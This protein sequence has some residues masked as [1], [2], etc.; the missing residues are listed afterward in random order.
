MILIFVPMHNQIEN[1]DTQGEIRRI[2]IIEDIAAKLKR[3]GASL[4]FTTTKLDNIEADHR[5]VEACAN[6]L[7]TLWLQGHVQDVSQAPITWR[8]F[9]EALRDCR[10]GQLA[11]TLTDL[12]TSHDD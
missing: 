2:F 4:K 7:L 5:E 6:R 1:T 11:D 8:T 9:L 12:L 10:L 3:L